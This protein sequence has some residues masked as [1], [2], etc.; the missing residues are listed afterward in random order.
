MTDATPPRSSPIESAAPGEGASGADVNGIDPNVGRRR[1][2]EIRCGFAELAR[3][4]ADAAEARVIETRRACDAQFG[5]LVESQAVLDLGGSQAAK[6]EAHRAFRKAVAAARERSHVEAAATAWLSEINRANGIM[7]TAQQGIRHERDAVELLR[8]QL[9]RLTVTAEASRTMAG[10]AAKACREA[11]EALAASEAGPTP[12]IAATP[13]APEAVA[14]SVAW[15][16]LAAALAVGASSPDLAEAPPDLAEAPPD[17]AEAPPD[18]AE[19][20]PDQ[21]VVDPA[22]VHA[23]AIVRL[24]R[25][26]NA[27]LT[28]IVDR[29]ASDPAARSR[30]QFLL[31]NFVDAVAA[32]A[33]DDGFFDFAEGSLFWDLFDSEQAREVARGLAALGFRY[34]GM[35]GFADGRVPGQRDLALAVGQAGMN[36]GRIRFWPHPAEAAEL[37]RNVR[38][39]SDSYI[40]YRAPALTLG[41]LVQILGRRAE[42]LTDLWNDWP[43]VRPLLFTTSGG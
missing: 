19:D 22:S 7:R 37:F 5:S 16:S 33:I 11:E 41:Q 6:E 23:Q 15:P 20:P 26:D 14:G 1:L 27:A 29:L 31:S 38:V 18:L 4:E 24:L 10:S 13:E 9:E 8:D 25:R 28:M 21:L 30:W 32:A 36:P 2:L 35:G 12:E 42:M 39:A 43:R 17:L 34:D 3:Q 40:A